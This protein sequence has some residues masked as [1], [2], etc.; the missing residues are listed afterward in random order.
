MCTTFSARSTQSHNS[1]NY[2]YDMVSVVW[3]VTLCSR[4]RAGMCYI[5][6]CMV[7]G[8]NSEV[9]PTRSYTRM[10]GVAD[11]CTKFKQAVRMYVY[12]TCHTSI[13][14]SS[15]FDRVNT[16]R[17]THLIKL[18]LHRP[19]TC[20]TRTRMQCKT[21]TGTGT[22]KVMKLSI[23]MTYHTSVAS[24]MLPDRARTSGVGH[25]F[26]LV[27]HRWFVQCHSNECKQLHMHGTSNVSHGEC[28]HGV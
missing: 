19:L 8:Q 25:L 23:Y 18:N 10:Y 12:V 14:S 13:A 22:S 17:V 3:I 11:E 20:S 26:E 6:G 1:L 16:C 9:V 28:T 4:S 24:V 5:T 27:P 15:C 2:C 21:R 7:V